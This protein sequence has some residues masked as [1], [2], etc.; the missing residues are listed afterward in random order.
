MANLHGRT[1]SLADRV[2][3]PMPIA[4]NEHLAHLLQVQGGL[5]DAYLEQNLG[6]RFAYVILVREQEPPGHLRAVTNVANRAAARDMLLGLRTDVENLILD[7]SPT[8]MD[9]GE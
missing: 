7:R 4:V 9:M 5:L 1:A 6:T 8:F 2:P 3:L